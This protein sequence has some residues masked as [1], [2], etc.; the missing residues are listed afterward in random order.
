[1]KVRVKGHLTLEF[2]TTW[3]EAMKQMPEFLRTLQDYDAYLELDDEQ[4]HPDGSMVMLVDPTGE[5]EN[6]GPAEVMGYE[7]CGGY[8]VCIP[9]E[10]RTDEDD[11]DGL[12]EV[13]QEQMVPI[14]GYQV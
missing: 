11:V 1:M 2:G 3:E 4:V 14:T 12:R 9:E 10:H 5:I 13:D 8:C 6:E 7:G